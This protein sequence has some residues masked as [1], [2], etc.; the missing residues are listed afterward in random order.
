M[1]IDLAS[2]ISIKGMDASSN[3]SSDVVD[4][5]NVLINL[6]FEKYLSTVTTVQELW[7]KESFVD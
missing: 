7:Q 4:F 3:L 2:S 5:R 6:K 1:S